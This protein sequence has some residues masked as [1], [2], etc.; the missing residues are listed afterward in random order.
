MEIPRYGSGALSDVVP[1]LLAGLDVPGTVDVLGV[2]GA[3][4]VCLLLIDGL[5]WELLRAHAD[6]APFLSSLPG[7]PIT[8]GFPSSTAT[9]IAALG[10]GLPTGEHGIVGY[11]FETGSVLLNSLGWNH[12]G[13]SDHADLR[14]TAVPEEVQPHPTTFDRAAAAGVTVRAVAPYQQEGSGL[15]RAVLRGALFH[16]VYA[17]G[18]LASAALD[19]LGSAD[20]VFCYAYHA[21]LDALGH[22]YGPDSEPWRFQLSY[23]D[24]VAA[25]IAARLPT[26]A[27]LTVVAD[28]GMVEL[29]EDNRI[30]F[31]TE[32]TL[33]AGVRLLGGEPRV[34]HVYTEPGAT[35]D[36]LAAWREVLGDRAWLL[37]RDEAIAL[38]LFGPS[39]A[40]HAYTRIGNLVVAARD[41]TA[42]VRTSVESRL[43][44]F[45]GQHGSLTSA[46]QLVPLLFAS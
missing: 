2:P 8:A 15:S 25:S 10:T 24:H 12:H 35:D 28:H 26:D 40:V 4:R 23:I 20:R 16:G 42:I 14:R 45:I 33:Q 18:D 6:A 46:E 29:S 7:K 3:R 5:G 39:V 22:L 38:G 36:V 44:S 19:A 30:D 37:R 43:S 27:V 9:S 1:S 31:D 41:T 32:P 21:D 13:T 34:R 17:L 11:S